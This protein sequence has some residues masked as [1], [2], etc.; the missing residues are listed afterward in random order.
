M[1]SIEWFIEEPSD[2]TMRSVVELVRGE[3]GDCLRLVVAYDGETLR[4]LHTDDEVLASYSDEE[5]ERGVRNLVLEH[6]IETLELSDQECWSEIMHFR[7]IS[8]LKVRYGDGE[9][10]L[11]SFDND[12]NVRLPAFSEDVVSLFR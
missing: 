9:Q 12:H 4:I 3:F 7:D 8:V 2:T 5:F 10:I 6:S 1:R 11:I